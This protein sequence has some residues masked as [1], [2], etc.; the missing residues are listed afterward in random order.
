MWVLGEFQ[1]SVRRALSEIDPDWEKYRGLVVCG[2]HSPN[3]EN[4]DEVL[5]S[6]SK[7]RQIGDPFLGICFGHQMAAVEY[8]RNVLGINAWSEEL[9]PINALQQNIVVKRKEGLKVGLHDGESWWNNYEVVPGFDDMWKKANNFITCQY[10]PEYQ[11]SKEKPH[12][13]LV[14]FLDYAKVAV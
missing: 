2:T 3:A 1:T 5:G 7:A 12:P 8:A 4:I 6:I 9:L 10:H 14:K 13:L 11:S